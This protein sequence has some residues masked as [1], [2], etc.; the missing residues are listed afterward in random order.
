MHSKLNRIHFSFLIIILGF[1]I[2]LIGANPILGFIASTDTIRTVED[3]DGADTYFVLDSTGIPHITYFN[4]VSETLDYAIK[5][6]D[7]WIIESIR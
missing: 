4:N 3:I 1:I 2:I 7:T 5:N 6:N